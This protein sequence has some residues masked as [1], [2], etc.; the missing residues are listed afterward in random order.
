MGDVQPADKSP[1][2][3]NGHAVTLD[4]NTISAITMSFE[5][6][7]NVKAYCFRGYRSVGNKSPKNNADPFQHRVFNGMYC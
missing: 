5:L 7:K 6:H 3:L 1:K 2:S 4:T